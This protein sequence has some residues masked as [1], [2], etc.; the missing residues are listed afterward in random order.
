MKF[1]LLFGILLAFVVVAVLVA[2]PVAVIAMWVEE[3]TNEWVSTALALV[4]ITAIVAG[5]VA[6][7]QSL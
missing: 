7:A 5:L 4:L 2:L 1:L 3:K 6:V